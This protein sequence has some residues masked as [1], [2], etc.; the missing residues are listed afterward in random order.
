MPLAV[1]NATF[2]YKKESCPLN[3]F[4]MENVVEEND[5]QTVNK[6]ALNIIYANL[7]KRVREH[8]GRAS[9]RCPSE[10]KLESYF[11]ERWGAMGDVND[12]ERGWETVGWR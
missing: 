9:R 4:V 11:E 6:Q 1:R 3:A 8:Y 5:A 2:A 10:K 7:V 12:G